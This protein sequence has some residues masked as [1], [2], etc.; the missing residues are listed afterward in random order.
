MVAFPFFFC[1]TKY[2]YYEYAVL[3]IKAEVTIPAGQSD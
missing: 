3:K 1:I 2:S